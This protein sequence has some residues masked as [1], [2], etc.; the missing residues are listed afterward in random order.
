MQKYSQIIKIPQKMLDE[1]NEILRL[2]DFFKDAGRCSVIET[3]TAI[4][5]NGWQADI[6]VCNGDGPYVDPVVFDKEGNQIACIEVADELD[7]EYVFAVPA[8]YSNSGDDEEYTIIVEA[9]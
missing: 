5:D 2:S 7:G 4:F 1:M 8:G 9:E 6:K 3:F